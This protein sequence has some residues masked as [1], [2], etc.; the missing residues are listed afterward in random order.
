MLITPSHR[1]MIMYDIHPDKHEEY[2]QYVL[3]EFV[4]ELQKMGLYMIYAWQVYGEN[5]PER[6]VEFVCES[7]TI[8]KNALLSPEFQQ[9]EERLKEY[10]QNYRR[11]VVIFK[12]R[13]QV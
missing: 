10:T 2:Y 5:Q 8:L 3:G 11:K 13:P 6:F 9:A 1:I 4:P 7:A 12:N